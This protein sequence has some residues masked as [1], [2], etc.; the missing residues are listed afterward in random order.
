VNALRLGVAFALLGAGTAPFAQEYAVAFN[1]FGPANT[2][3]FIADGNGANARPL[4][5]HPALDY[6]ASFSVDGAWIVFTSERGGFADI[7]RAHPDGSGLERL[8]EHA[9]FDDQGLLSPDGRSL[10]FVSSRGGQADIFVL[11]LET[12]AVRALVSA[13][14]G[15]FRPTWSPDG[16]FVAFVSDRDAPRTTCANSGATTG[17]GPFVTPQYTGVFVVRADGTEPRRIS[18][19]AEVAGG[20]AW[21]ADGTRLLFH[22]AQPDSVCTGELMFATGTSQIVAVDIASG[23]RTTLTSGNGVKFFPRPSGRG[24]VAYTTATG[25]AFTAATAPIAGQFGRPEWSHDG[26]AIVFHRDTGQRSS[27][28]YNAVAKPSPDTRFALRALVGQASF[29]PDG[30]QMAYGV[31][32]FVAGGPGAGQLIVADADGANQRTIFQGPAVDNLTAPAWSPRGDVVVFGLGA[33]FRRAE[34]GP[35]GLLSIGTDGSNLTPLSDGTTNEG[36]PSFSPDGSELVF[37]I[38]SGP[39]RGIYVLNLANGEKRHLQTGSERDTFPS[40]SPRG[41]WITFTSQRDGN[42][43]IYRIRPDG[44]NVERLT[45][46]PGHDAHSSISP[47]GEWI[48]FATGQQGFKDEALGLFVGT[49]PP[50]FQSYGEIGVMRIDGSDFRLL[51]DNS[52]E[53]G[54]P[55]WVPRRNP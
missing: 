29:S 16:R 40:W 43:E 42:Y 27:P 33:Y 35:A 21:S 55:V 30:R 36:M 6:N 10:A 7:Y 49:R 38:V 28:P 12:R 1:S 31:T 3:I 41:D 26:S 22:S 5:P 4:A 34:T 19:A 15:E 54:V 14:S 25:I 11:D 20:P 18:E 46:F 44:T 13:P 37:R 51:T 45:R 52:V 53:E 23:V 2:D 9:S 32:S 50:P 24:S 8:T 48:A 47:D 17:P 39:T